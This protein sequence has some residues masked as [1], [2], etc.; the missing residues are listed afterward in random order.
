[1]SSLQQYGR[2]KCSVFFWQKEGKLVANVWLII[3]WKERRRKN[4]RRDN[5]NKQK[6]K[7]DFIDILAMGFQHYDWR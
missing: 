3:L 6:E 1:M 4:E 2:R 5:M 7:R